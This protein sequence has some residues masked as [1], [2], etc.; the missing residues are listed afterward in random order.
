MPR[1]PVFIILELFYV[2]LDCFLKDLSVLQQNEFALLNLQSSSHKLKL[3][4]NSG[5]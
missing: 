4:K 1:S 2:K 3:V 5:L